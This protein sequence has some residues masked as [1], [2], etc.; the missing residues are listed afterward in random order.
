VT[1]NVN[2][3]RVYRN[4]SAPGGAVA[5]NNGNFANGN[6]AHPTLLDRAQ[7]ASATPIRGVLP[8][9][10]TAANLAYSAH[11]TERLLSAP[12]A[13]ARFAQFAT[14]P[15]TA[16]A[17]F[18]A[19]QRK[20]QSAA[21]ASYPEHAAVFQHPEVQRQYDRPGLITNGD[22]R[23][24]MPAADRTPVDRTPAYLEVS[25]SGRPRGIANSSQEATSGENVARAAE[26]AAHN[27]N[28]RS[29]GH[30]P[31]DANPRLQCKAPFVRFERRS[32]S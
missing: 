20:V 8:V 6:F 22:E 13:A 16:V 28:A 14:Q 29:A 2:I 23:H 15:R 30:G 11:V 19:Q 32:P 25:R 17:P 31:V 27:L 4:L 5:V 7:L 1:V 12:P 26:C 3:T 10:P 18:A 21:I 9:V 24:D